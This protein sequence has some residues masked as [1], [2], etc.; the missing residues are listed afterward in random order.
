M[1]YVASQ[2][3]D[4]DN[5]EEEGQAVLEILEAINGSCEDEI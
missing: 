2:H 1:D 5:Q 3:F 4:A